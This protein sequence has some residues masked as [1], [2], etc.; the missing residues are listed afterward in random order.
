MKYITTPVTAYTQNCSIA[1]C[2]ETLDCCIIDP[3]GNIEKLI[4]IIEK[5][6][7][8]PVA[9]FLTHGHLDHVGGTAKLAEYYT[10]PIS[11]PHKEDQF[12]LDL[13]PKQA[14][15]FDFPHCDVFHP[16]QWLAAGDTL[17]F[18]NES[19][20]VRFTPGHTPGHIVLY[21]EHDKVVFVGDVI[22]AGAVGRTDF[23]RGDHQQLMD[24]IQTQLLSLDDDVTIVS[25][26][27]AETTIGHERH[28]NPFLLFDG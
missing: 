14:E 19:F 16:N 13:L 8:H 6:Q 27:G 15:M 28:H 5:Q 2:E 22:F 1:W 12:W 4:A 7:L 17:H 25:G 21:H 3:G 23:P 9:I 18:G 11:G 26:H 20:S 24:S 10:I